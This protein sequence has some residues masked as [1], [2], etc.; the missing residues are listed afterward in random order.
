MIPP[1]VADPAAENAVVGGAAFSQVAEP[2][3]VFVAPVSVADVAG[4]RA[5]FDTAFVFDVSGPVS[6]GTVG[7]DSSGHPRF[8]AFPNDDYFASS[9]SSNEVDG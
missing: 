5:S 3:V 1:G 2:E 8:F 4:P 6:L 7:V 9:S